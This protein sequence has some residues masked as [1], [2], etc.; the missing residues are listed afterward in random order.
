MT[1]TRIEVR[2]Y[3]ETA[4]QFADEAQRRGVV[5]SKLLKQLIVAILDDALI[6]AVLDERKEQKEREE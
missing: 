1:G 3:G 5:P 6:D 4:E 2:L